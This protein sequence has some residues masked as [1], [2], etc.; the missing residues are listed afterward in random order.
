MPKMKTRKSAAQ[1]TIGSQWNV[2]EPITATDSGFKT[3]QR[4]SVQS[5]QSKTD[6]EQ[7]SGK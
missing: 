6:R 3:R 5:A 2:G 7:G 4:K 1:A